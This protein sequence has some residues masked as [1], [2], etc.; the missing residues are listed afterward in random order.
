[1]TDSRNLIG[2]LISED[3]AHHPSPAIPRQLVMFQQMKV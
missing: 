1:L 2:D 3:F